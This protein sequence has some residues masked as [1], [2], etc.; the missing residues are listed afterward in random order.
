MKPPASATAAN[1]RATTAPIRSVRR[2]C[3]RRFRQASA[4]SFIAP[5]PSSTRPSSSATTRRARATTRGSWVAKRNATPPESQ[6][7]RI[8]S[9]IPSAVC[10]SRLAVGSSAKTT[11]GRLARARA[12]A[13]RWRWPPERRSGRTPYFPERPTA[14]SSSR[15]RRRRSAARHA[16]QDHR[17]GDVLLGREDGDQVERLEHEPEPVAPQ[18]RALVLRE[19]AGLDPADRDL[20][21]VGT[22]EQTEQIQ[23]RRLSR[24]ARPL[25]GDELAAAD[26]ERHVLHRRHDRRAQAVE[27]GRL[28]RGDDRRRPGAAFR[29]AAALAS[30]PCRVRRQVLPPS[31]AGSLARRRRLTGAPGPCYL[32]RCSRGPSG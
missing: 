19:V 11:S 4:K 8:R 12:I 1:P 29:R 10:E 7:S 16:A 15:A 30:G 9:R 6:T 21:L 14:S 28:A 23:E 17:V 18:V 22:V 27:P 24:T 3:R 32:L 25:Q 26:R 20:S 31:G 13:T 5:R 2:R